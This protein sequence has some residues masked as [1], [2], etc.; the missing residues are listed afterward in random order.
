M[1][2]RID[3]VCIIFYADSTA[4]TVAQISDGEYLPSPNQLKGKILLKGS[5]MPL[6]VASK[7]AQEAMHN[8]REE[9][10][11]AVSDKDNEPPCDDSAQ[12]YVFYCCC[13]LTNTR[14]NISITSG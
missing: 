6:R 9:G 1:L 10:G 5:C 7:L 4:N 12:F 14:I 8:G 11:A 13:V 3:E 2:L